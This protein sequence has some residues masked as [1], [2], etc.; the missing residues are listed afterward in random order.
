M[1]ILIVMTHPVGFHRTKQSGSIST[2][3][4][5]FFPGLELGISKNKQCTSIRL[6]LVQFLSLCLP[7]SFV[8]SIKGFCSPSS[9][10]LLS[11]QSPSLSLSSDHQWQPPTIAI[12]SLS[13]LPTR[14]PKVFIPPFRFYPIFP[15]LF[16]YFLQF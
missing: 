5:H 13:P 8:H 7:A 11:P 10:A 1:G 16:Q 2:F 12:L 3:I 4:F 6:W 9:I 14:S 15:C